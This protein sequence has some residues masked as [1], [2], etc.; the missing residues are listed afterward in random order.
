MTMHPFILCI[1]LLIVE[2]CCCRCHN[3]I[4]SSFPPWPTLSVPVATKSDVRNAV[5]L[6]SRG[7]GSSDTNRSKFQVQTNFVYYLSNYILMD[8]NGFESSFEK[9]ERERVEKRSDKPMSPK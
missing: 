5:V 1:K 8:W 3:S 4:V 2:N 7:L 9:K 6:E